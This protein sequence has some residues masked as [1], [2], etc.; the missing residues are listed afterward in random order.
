MEVDLRFLFFVLFNFQKS[1]KYKI[2]KQKTKKRKKKTGSASKF[3]PAPIVREGNVIVFSIAYRMGPFA[4]LAQRNLLI[5]EPS[6]G[7]FFLSF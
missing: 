1:N 2:K 4:N 5:D 7:L 3:N 6:S